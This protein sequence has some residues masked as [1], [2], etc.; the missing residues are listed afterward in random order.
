MYSLLIFT[1]EFHLSVFTFH[2]LPHYVRLNLLPLTRS[3]HLLNCGQGN[4]FA[5][6]SLFL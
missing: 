5:I 4:L 3:F 6:L 1:A 2:L